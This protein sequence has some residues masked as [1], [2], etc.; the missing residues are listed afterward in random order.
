MSA[1][2]DVIGH[3]FT[4]SASDTGFSTTGEVRGDSYEEAVEASVYLQDDWRVSP[5]FGVNVGGRLY[6]YS[7]GDYVR[8]EP[9]LGASY[10]L[11]DELKAKASVA[12][13]HQFLHLIVRN[14]ISVPSG[15]WFPA[16]DVV[17]PARSLQSTIGLEANL[18]ENAYL[19]TL[20][21]YYKDLKASDPCSTLPE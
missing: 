12:M 13:A 20:E 3:R 15:L 1:G 9:R 14:D 2:I 16:T 8:A 11:T 10:A 21:G 4:L 19:F 6:Y 5:V 7:N 17:R 18:F